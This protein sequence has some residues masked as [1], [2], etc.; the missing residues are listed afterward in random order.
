MSGRNY[1]TQGTSMSVTTNIIIIN[2]LML[3]ATFVLEMKG[4]DLR[5]ILGLHYWES[6]EFQPY[7]MITYMFMHADISHI[8]FNM[9]SIFM[10]GRLLESV[11][12][13][14][15][16]LIYYLVTGVGAAITQQLAWM[17]EISGIVNQINLE[18]PD[19]LI[20]YGE[21]IQQYS[22]LINR[23]VTIGASGGVFGILLAFGMM[24]PNARLILLFPPIPI[25]AKWL[26]IGYGLIE[27]ITGVAGTT[28][29][30]NVAHFAHLGG[31][32]FGFFFIFLWRRHRRR[33]F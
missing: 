23:F 3:L 27:L 6:D 9:F 18:N 11:W 28:S 33:M 20:S 1:F 10:F 19:A 17:W 25:K 8:F 26:V 14:G 7:Q 12:G 13:G 15:R 30:D 29:F 5:H 24:F 31:M 21:F 16:Y 32:I 4:I 22:D 2:A